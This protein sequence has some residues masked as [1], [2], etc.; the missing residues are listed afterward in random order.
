MTDLLDNPT[1]YMPAPSPISGETRDA[2]AAPSPETAR[3][4]SVHR[5]RQQAREMR[6]IEAEG[7]PFFLHITGMEAKVRRLSF[8]DKAMLMG[9]PSHLQH[10]LSAAY[11]QFSSNTTQKT[12][13]VQDMARAA[14]NDERIANALCCAGFLEPRLTMT[15]AEADLAR[16]DG[17][18]WVGDLHI[19]ERKRYMN[20]VLGNGGEEDLKRIAGFLDTRLES[21]ATG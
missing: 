13:T 19:E 16:D 4:E 8:A 14:A 6:R 21:A 17:V 1:T 5:T 3:R 18:W 15:E 12:R 9:L 7:V 11:N 20:L 2:Y 10:E